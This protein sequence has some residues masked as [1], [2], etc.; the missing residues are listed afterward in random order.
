MQTALYGQIPN[1]EETAISGV[2][3]SF[4]T[5]TP[6]NEV[7]VAVAYASVAGLLHFLDITKARA[8]GTF[9]SQ[10]LFGLDDYLTQPGVLRTCL[11][12]PNA[13][14]RTARL[15]NEGRRFHPKLLIVSQ[16]RTRS[17]ACV[18]SSNLTIGGMK[19][20]CEAFAALTATTSSE[21]NQLSNTWESI[22]QLGTATTEADI[23]AYE[24]E[25]N[26]HAPNWPDTDE[27][28]AAEPTEETDVRT[29]SRILTSDSATIDPSLAKTCWIEV[30]KNTA[31]GRELEF[32]AEQALFFGLS[33][34]GG[35]PQY[36][37]FIVSSGANV[38]LRLKYQE[39]AMWRLQMNNDIP[40]VAIGLRPRDRRTG[41][42]GRSPYVA[43]FSRA[44]NRNTYFLKF[45]RDDSSEYQELRRQSSR[46]G[47]SG[48]TSAR[49]YGWC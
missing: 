9:T 36:R 13:E 43:V 28:P 48:S 44:D 37:A 29:E 25:Y 49:R 23:D 4:S 17:L 45:I 26:V 24:A 30:G 40:E 39:N 12:L 18:G 31:M 3:K 20:N 19:G 2:I 38:P 33:P 10:W 5:A 21:I 16:N 47:T 34:S 14:L 27:I 15:L 11:S 32:K 7:R 35:P 42:L 46:T 6:W 1:R 22:W 41:Q 8:R